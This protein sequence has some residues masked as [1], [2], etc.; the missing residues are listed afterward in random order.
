[1]ALE[2]HYYQHLEKTIEG[3]YSD[4]AEASGALEQA[5]TATVEN[6]E[7]GGAVEEVAYDRARAAVEDEYDE[8]AVRAGAL[9]G[10]ARSLMDALKD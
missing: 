2:G 10:A 7:P 3:S 1:M 8:Y 5:I 4:Y 9:E 6:T